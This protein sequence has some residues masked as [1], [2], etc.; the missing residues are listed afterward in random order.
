VYL[1]FLRAHW[2]SSDDRKIKES[3]GEMM[4]DR[5]GK[6]N[7]KTATFPRTTS[8]SRYTQFI[9][10]IKLVDKNAALYTR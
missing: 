1:Q 7:I 10:S 4:S 9:S 6:R 2:T 8:S 3:A 5:N